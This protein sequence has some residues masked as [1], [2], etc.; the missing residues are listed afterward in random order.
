MVLGDMD[1]ARTKPKPRPGGKPPVRNSSETNPSSQ[2]RP[3][4]FGWQCKI[5]LLPGGR[6]PP[7]ADYMEGGRGGGLGTTC[8]GEK[9]GIGW[10]CVALLS[11]C[12]KEIS[13]RTCRRNLNAV[14]RLFCGISF[15]KLFT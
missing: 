9:R 7:G 1:V 11:Q 2:R 5:G 14:D 3:P 4:A 8:G 15:Y 10:Q 13:N 6:R 12:I